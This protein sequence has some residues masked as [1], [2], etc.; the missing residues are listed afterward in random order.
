MGAVVIPRNPAARPGARTAKEGD[1]GPHLSKLQGCAKTIPHL[2][3]SLLLLFLV[4]IVSYK[5]LG[6]TASP[7]LPGAQIPTDIWVAG[8]LQP[9]KNLNLLQRLKDSVHYSSWVDPLGW[10]YN[11]TSEQSHQ[12]GPPL[13]SPPS[14]LSPKTSSDL[15]PA[16]SCSPKPP[17]HQSR[18]GSG[19]T[20][21]GPCSGAAFASQPS[22][23][24]A[25]LGLQ[26]K[27]STHL[28][29]PILLTGPP[30]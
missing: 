7:G 10:R 1:H 3:N 5:D 8:A 6:A 11:S 21:A 19:P 27:H 25:S 14:Q 13:I 18:G 17:T 28:Q 2:H 9:P 4:T 15:N 26:G 16:G 20:R 24:K 23:P 22:L 12:Q 29:L 30:N